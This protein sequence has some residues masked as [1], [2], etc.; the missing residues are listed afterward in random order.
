MDEKK[1][2]WK[3][4]WDCRRMGE[5]EGVFIATDAEIKAALGKNVYFGEILGKHSEIQGV[6]EEKDLTRLTDDQEFISKAEQY[7]LSRSGYNPLEYLHEEDEEEE[8]EEDE[9]ARVVTAGVVFAAAAVEEVF[10]ASLPPEARTGDAV[11]FAASLRSVSDRA[12]EIRPS[13]PARIPVAWCFR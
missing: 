10:A 9:R 1:V 6:L 8:R 13:V 3:F 2:V 11:G 5:V 12:K 7:G 4:Y